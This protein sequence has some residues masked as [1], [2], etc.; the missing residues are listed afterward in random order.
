[1]IPVI[2]Y[3]KTFKTDVIV[4]ICHIKPTD[5]FQY[6]SQFIDI[7]NINQR[8]KEKVQITDKEETGKHSGGIKNK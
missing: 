4:Y 6:Q 8:L 7:D 3:I 1:M 5:N 2:M